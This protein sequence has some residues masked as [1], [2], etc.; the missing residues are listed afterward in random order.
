MR[1]GR[2][3][4]GGIPGTLQTEPLGPQAVVGGEAAAAA[5]GAAPREGWK[6]EVLTSRCVKL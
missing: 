1:P 5:A 3:G 6:N 4:R 2:V